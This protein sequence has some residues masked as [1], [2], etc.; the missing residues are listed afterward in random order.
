MNKE[1]IEQIIRVT[2][3]DL[4][5]IN[6]YSARDAL[7]DVA[8]KALKRGV[9]NRDPIF[10]PAG[11]LMLG[12]SEAATSPSDSTSE[13]ISKELNSEIIGN[14]RAYIDKWIKSGKEVSFVDDSV[15][16]I[17]MI[18]LYE[19]TGE[20]QFHHGAAKIANFLS[21]ATKNDEE[22]IIYNPA[23]GND[24]IYADGAGQAAMFLAKY[25]TVFHKRNAI[26]L[27]AKQLI[28]FYN[29]GF[30]KKSGL[31]YHAFSLAEEKKAGI[32]GWGRAVGWLMLGYSEIL[33]NIN[34]EENHGDG[35]I[36]DA[37]LKSTSEKLMSEF[38]SLIKV[39][40]EYQRPDGG[41]SWL[42]PAVEGEADTSATAMIAYSMANW[43]RSGMFQSHAKE[44]SEEAKEAIQRAKDFLLENTE[45]GSVLQSLSSCEDLAVHRQIYGHYPWGQGSAL[46]FFSITD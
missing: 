13:L 15:A 20:R 37:I 21:Q 1:T 45:N 9:T 18:K 5:E 35:P 14:L 6:N 30:D 46:A 28:N 31:P 25:G 17:T 12:L 24:L 33:S 11:L 39:T 19:A 16:G 41:F 34:K 22:S 2:E 7:K 23:R 44:L 26:A 36:G 43:L 40:L 27:A 42:L 10:W 29:N 38:Y 8:K 32:I 4:S 3:K